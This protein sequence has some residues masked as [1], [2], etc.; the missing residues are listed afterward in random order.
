LLERVKGTVEDVAETIK[1]FFVGPKVHSASDLFF[2]GLSFKTLPWPTTTVK[3]ASM[4]HAPT[5]SA[6][7]PFASAPTCVANLRF[8]SRTIAETGGAFETNAKLIEASFV[9]TGAVKSAEIQKVNA[10]G[11][12]KV[13]SPHYLFPTKEHVFLIEP[14]KVKQD[15]VYKLNTYLGTTGCYRSV[16]RALLIPIKIKSENLEKLSK[17]LWMRYT[18]MLVKESGENVKNIEMVGIY[19]VPKNGVKTFKLDPSTGS[20]LIVV[21][22]DA[23]QSPFRKIIIAR[24]KNNSTLV[25]CA[26]DEN[27]S[28]RT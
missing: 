26:I 22:A 5:I 21:G 14:L 19:R 1:R 20:L 12:T 3:E 4:L 6:M 25:S 9:W 8:E 2:S 28:E 7:P 11:I 13:D 24:R 10:P 15:G 27:Y 23:L 17:A 18:M 16:E